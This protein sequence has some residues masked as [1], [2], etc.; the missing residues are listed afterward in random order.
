MRGNEQIDHLLN[1]FNHFLSCTETG[2]DPKV[3][4]LTRIGLWNDSPH[5]YRYVEFTFFQ[6]AQQFSE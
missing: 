5:D 1:N 6:Q 2:L 4:Q 3:Q